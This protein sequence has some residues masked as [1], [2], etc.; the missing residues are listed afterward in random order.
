MPLTA[1]TFTVG[2]AVT[3]ISEMSVDAQISHIENLEPALDAQDLTR[4]GYVYLLAQK[5]DVVGAGTAVFNIATGTDGLQIQFYEIVTTT[6]SVYAELIEGATSTVTGDAIPAYNLN[7]AESDAHEA[8]FKA[9]TSYTGGTTISAELLTGTKQAGSS[10]QLTKLHTLE[11]DSDYVMK[12]TNVG[13]QTTTVFLQVAFAEKYNGMTEVW[14]GDT[15][16]DG[17]RLRGGEK[18]KAELITGQSVTAVSSGSVQ[19]GVLRQD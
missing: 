3:T 15:V 17:Y 19:V 12:F 8:V 13:N 2:T 16:G 1:N 7:R 10:M 9:V 5:F 4:A 6:S 18:I 11:P 14:L